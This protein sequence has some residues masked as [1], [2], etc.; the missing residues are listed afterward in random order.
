MAAK[1][2]R[3]SPL[4]PEPL[5]MPSP[6]ILYRYNARVLDPSTAI[7]LPGQPRLRT[8]TYF[9]D[10]LL[11]SRVLPIANAPLG[12]GG[13]RRPARPSCR[14]S[15]PSAKADGATTRRR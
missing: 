2:R 12:A 3:R 11:V 9:A 8:T 4:P 15:C 1:P 6:D 13:E 7:T 14:T 5:L 10:R